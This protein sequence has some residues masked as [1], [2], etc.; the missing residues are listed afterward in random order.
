MIYK[1]DLS[2]DKNFL[3]EFN[4]FKLRRNEN[5]Y[6]HL[7]NHKISHVQFKNN[8]SKPILIKKQVIFGK[9]MEFNENECYLANAKKKFNFNCQKQKNYTSFNV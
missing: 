7:T 2:Q 8:F 1:N 3:F 5:L 4:K 6:F 9:L